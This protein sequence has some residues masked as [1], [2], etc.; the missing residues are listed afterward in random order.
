MVTILLR[1]LLIYGILIGALRLMG[2]RQIGELEISELVTTL[3][4]SEIA[5]LP[6]ENPEY[7]LL[8]SFLPI[9][10]LLLL[11]FLASFLLVRF[12]VL[13]HLFSSRPTV[14]VRSGV[15]LEKELRKARVSPEELISALRQKEISDIR[16]VEYAILESN[17]QL[18]VIRSAGASPP[19]ADDLGVRVSASDITRILVSNGR[20]DRHGV[21]ETENGEKVIERALSKAKCRL[22]DVFLM[23]SGKDGK[24]V[25][26]KKDESALEISDRSASSKKTD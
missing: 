21:K 24:V 10:T 19:S 3:L 16:E 22:N 1:T 5:V 11:E 23:L 12:P 8:H 15:P 6:I 26:I 13:K 25:V 20:I 4:I 7:P 9:V 17:G 18:S 2:K 14:V